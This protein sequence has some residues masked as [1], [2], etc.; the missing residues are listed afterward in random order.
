MTYRISIDT[1]GTF[2]DAVVADASGIL[3]LGKALTDPLRNFTGVQAAIADAGQQLG[4]S[5]RELLGQTALFIY[6]TT[7]ATN[8]IVTGR[9]ARTAML[10][11]EGFPDILVYRQGGK[12]NP[13]Q[14]NVDYPEPYIPRALTFEV[15]ERIDAEGGVVGKGVDALL[16]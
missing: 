10:L 5:L 1:G 3:A 6:G 15:P 8:A 9:T 12:L 4:L 7:R 13:H 16:Q 14:L 11:T 2:T